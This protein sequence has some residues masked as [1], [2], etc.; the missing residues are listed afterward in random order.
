MFML[1]A[2]SFCAS[3]TVWLLKS[4][5]TKIVAGVGGIICV[6]YIL[7]GYYLMAVLPAFI[8]WVAIDQLRTSRMTEASDWHE[9]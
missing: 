7:L 3:L 5:A 2:L 1:G 8:Y 4:K 9:S 6:S